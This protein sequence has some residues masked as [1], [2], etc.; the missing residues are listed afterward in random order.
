MVVFQLLLLIAVIYYLYSF[1]KDYDR[2]TE[3]IRNLPDDTPTI[4][5][6]TND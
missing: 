5:G 3:E 4:F 6:D 1:I 2:V